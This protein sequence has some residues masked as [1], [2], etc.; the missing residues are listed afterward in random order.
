MCRVLLPFA[1]ILAALTLAAPAT[2]QYESE[3]LAPVA[4][5]FAMGP[6]SV[7]CSTP[8]E[9][10]SLYFAWGYVY[11]FS[12]EINM[13]AYLCAA[14]ERVAD[15]F[16]GMSVRALAVMVLVHEAFHLR[17]SWSARGDEAKVQCKA[18]RH[19]RYAAMMLGASPEL[20][21]QL[22][23]YALV[24]HWRIAALIPEYHLE[25]CRVPRP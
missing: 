21:T 3:K 16:V 17:K 11:L 22:R 5:V 9:G 8:A 6:V 20:A 19:F 13:T 10:A 23:A 18:I 7:M 24:H 25:K 2:G 12:T 15:P 1:A 14:A 4:S